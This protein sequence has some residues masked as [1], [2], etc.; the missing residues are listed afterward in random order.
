MKDK[1]KFISNFSLHATYFSSGGRGI[2]SAS[3]LGQIEKECS[4]DDREKRT[5]KQEGKKIPEGKANYI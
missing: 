2:A 5:T 4:Q 3:G 1:K